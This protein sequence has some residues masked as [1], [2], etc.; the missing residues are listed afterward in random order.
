M[1][2]YSHVTVQTNHD[3][4]TDRQKLVSVVREAAP[5]PG[6]TEMCSGF[7]LQAHL[8]ATISGEPLGHLFSSSDF[9]DRV[10]RDLMAPCQFPTSR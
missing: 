1:W 10:S 2:A 8:E 9:K 7:G 3:E 4:F 6:S 5:V